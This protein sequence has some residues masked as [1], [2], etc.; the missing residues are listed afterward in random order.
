MVHPLLSSLESLPASPIALH[1]LQSASTSSADPLELLRIILQKELNA[2]IESLFSDYIRLY[3]L[4]AAKNVE[5]NLGGVNAS[6]LLERTCINALEH[7]KTLFKGSFSRKR[8]SQS[9]DPSSSKEPTIKKIKN[10][11]RGFE[12]ECLFVLS[13]QAGTAILGGSSSGKAFLSKHPQIFK[14]AA[15]Q[16]DKEWLMKERLISTSGGKATLVVLRDVLALY[17]SSSSL[18][19]KESSLRGFKLPDF[20]LEKVN[21]VFNSS[22]NAVKIEEGDEQGSRTTEQLAPSSSEVAELLLHEMK[23]APS[24][25]GEEDDLGFLTGMNLHSLVREFEMEAGAG[26]QHLGILSLADDSESFSELS[27]EVV[28]ESFDSIEFN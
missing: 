3:L 9:T 14:Y 12:P 24:A 22:M 1:R 4:P 7:A 28:Q 26:S 6:E 18:E 19:E 16:E 25:P 11:R 15:D 21:A 13:G 20:M 2:K 17:S 10:E 8:G 27:N 5:T 23:A